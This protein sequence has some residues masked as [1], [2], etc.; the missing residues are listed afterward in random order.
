MHTWRILLIGVVLVLPIV[1]ATSPS[2]PHDLALRIDGTPT[3]H[4]R[5]SVTLDIDPHINVGNVTVDLFI[6]P[7]WEK[8]PAGNRTLTLREKETRALTWQV[9]PKSEGFWT[10][11]AH[12][13]GYGGSMTSWIQ[14]YGFLHGN[15]SRQAADPEDVIPT[16]VVDL[17]FRAVEQTPPKVTLIATAT[18][19]ASW[20]RF[21]TLSTE[22][23]ILNESETAQ[24]PGSRALVASLTTYVPP[25]YG[26][27]AWSQ[28][29]FTPDWRTETP[30]ATGRPG[31]GLGC[32]D[33]WITREAGPAL[34]IEPS[35]DC[36]EARSH[37][38]PGPGIAALALV[39]ATAAGIRRRRSA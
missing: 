17:Q 13:A 19:R 6:P 3:L 31:I 33:L 34:D 20:M 4:E 10:V 29:G 1:S 38:A 8:S 23:G 16:P 5:F 28:F 35:R 37:L 18:P 25:H 36:E 30:P 11:R 9:T 15:E 14:H 39:G 22:F 26:A 7:D 12:L 27:R 2:S 21:G 32:R 24:G